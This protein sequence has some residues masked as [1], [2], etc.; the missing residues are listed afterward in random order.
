MKA[1]LI[2]L[3]K[4]VGCMNCQYACSFTQADD[5]KE[6]DANIRVNYYPNDNVTVTLSCLHCDNP[7][8]QSVCP[9]NA[10]TRD[11]DTNAVI[12]NSDKCSGCKMCIEAC[13]YGAIHFNA[14]SKTSV[15]CD[16]CG[17]QPNCVK[18]CI[19][20]ALTYDDVDPSTSKCKTV[21]HLLK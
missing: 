7:T 4:C 12:I 10:I 5:F 11:A 19:S 20:G 9:S 18:H 6:D 3:S 17:G 21:R 15:K 2:D 14:N 8:C 16:L 1:V 13:P